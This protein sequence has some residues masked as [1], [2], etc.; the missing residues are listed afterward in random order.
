MTDVRVL[1]RVEPQFRP[2]LVEAD[3]QAI[4]STVSSWV[5][6]GLTV[7]TVRGRKMRTLSGLFDEFAAALQFPLYF[8]ENEDSFNVCIAEL[9]MLPAGEGYVV[10]ITEPDQVLADEEAEALG[11]LTRSLESAANEW[12]RPV[13]LGEWWDRP[14]VPFHVVLTGARDSIARASI[15]GQMQA[16]RRHHS[17]RCNARRP[18]GSPRQRQE[19]HPR[20]RGRRPRR[21]GR[22][23]RG[24][25]QVGRRHRRD[26][27]T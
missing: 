8:G 20:S 18:P 4:G 5:Q 14:A 16:R 1:L 27:P 22:P 17:D 26:D 21:P 23:G 3:R 13:E 19:R 9:E 2:L 25:P 24:D 7:R 10:T 6:S 12:G 15:D 11:W